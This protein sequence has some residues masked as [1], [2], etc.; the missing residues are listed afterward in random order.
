MKKIIENFKNCNILV[1]GDIMLDKY[2]FGSTSRINPE[3]PV[4][5]VNVEKIEHRLGGAANVANNI[6]S[7]GGKCTLI[8]QAG[9]DE[10]KDLLEK[11][12]IKKN[13]NYFFIKTNKTIK[14]TRIISQNQHLIRIDHENNKKIS[15]EDSNN[16]INFIKN[17]SFDLIVISDY[18]KGFITPYLMEQ[19]KSLNKKIIADFKPQNIDL[20]KNIFVISPNLKEAETITNEIKIEKILQKLSKK[21][22]SN[23]ILT[24]GEK[25]AYLFEKEKKQQ[26]YLPSKAKE[27]YDVSGA[28]DTFIATV[29]LS[30]ATNTNLYESVILG[31]EAAGIVVGKLG[32]ATL[33]SSE[34]KKIIKDS[35][36]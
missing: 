22:N 17:K 6:T 3:A 34:L 29:A 30:I 13:I 4:P 23:I 5:I 14:K 27:V 31:N 28:G 7:L 35:K 9:N 12:L 8:G 11:E 33:S 19:L 1:I 18:N 15:D 32:T 26:Y 24:C 2:I 20:F 10:T 25:G 36:A 16:I 21:T